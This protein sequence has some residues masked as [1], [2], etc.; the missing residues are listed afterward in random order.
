MG[1]G[2][3]FMLK[4]LERN[5]AS[6][7]GRL[8]L[9]APPDQPIPGTFQNVT[10]DST[11]HERLIREMQRLRGSVYLQDGAVQ[12]E[13]LS[14]D[15]LHKTPED[16]R[17]WHLLI[18]DKERHVSSCAWYMLHD[19][20]QFDKLRVRNCPLA[21]LEE[22]RDKFWLA[23]ESELERARRNCMRYAELGGW[24]IARESRG[25][26]DCLLLALATYT[27]ARTLGPALGLTMATVRNSSAAILRRLGGSNLEVNG[28][29]VP[30]YYDPKYKCEMELLRFDSREPAAKYT[31]LI[32]LFM[33]QL[34]NVA[35]IASGVHGS[36]FGARREAQLAM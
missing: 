2:G 3:R 30:S 27:L 18:L 25:S 17:S 19:S 32:E 22:W 12:R 9:L 14:P 6:V 8:V 20:A 13:Q 23:V 35:V 10:Y 4:L 26:S 34:T 31:G 21:R 1:Q 15:G 11:T 5:I 16:E 33:E 28:S 24:A 29:P 36:A 7:D